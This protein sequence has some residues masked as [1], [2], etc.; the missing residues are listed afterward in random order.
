MPSLQ[1][2]NT[3]AAGITV[4]RLQASWPAPEVMRRCESPNIFAAF[5]TASTSLGSKCV[6]GLRQIRSNWTSTLTGQHGM[7]FDRWLVYG[8]GGV[9][10]ANDKFS[11]NRYTFPGTVD[12]TDTRIGWTV[13]AGVEYAFAPAWSAKLEYNFMD[14]GNHAVS[15]A[16]GTSTDI[17]QQVHA[18]KFGVNY[19]FG[20]PGLVNARY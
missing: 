10:W 2:T 13:G 12:V 20:F 17:D 19:K 16:P 7:A 6:G 5:S 3:I 14:F 11:T 15:F 18:V 4:L 1:G 9:A 8:K